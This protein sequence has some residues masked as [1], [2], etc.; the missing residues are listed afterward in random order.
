MHGDFNEMCSQEEKV[1]RRP[2]EDR[3]IDLLRS[4]LSDS[5]LMDMELKGCKFT[6]VSNPREGTITKEKIDRVLVNWDWRLLYPKDIAVALPM[7]NS[8]HS[9]IIIVPAS[10]DTSGR[11]FKFEAM[12]Q[13]HPEFDYVLSNSWNSIADNSPS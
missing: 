5:C 7:I 6:W 4:F 10:L 8:D 9:P 2:V 13:E 12:W 11:R 1:G 3:R